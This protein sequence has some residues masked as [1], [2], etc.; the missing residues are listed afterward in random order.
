M[1]TEQKS[2]GKAVQGLCN[3]WYGNPQEDQIKIF[4]DNFQFYVYLVAIGKLGF[5]MPVMVFSVIYS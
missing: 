3:G 4:G 1:K 5:A 2:R